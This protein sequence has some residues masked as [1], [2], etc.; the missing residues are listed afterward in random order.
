MIH[1]KIAFAFL[2]AVLLLAAPVRAE[3][4]PGGTLDQSTWEQAKGMLPEEILNHYRDGKLV[5]PVGTAVAPF[6]L[7]KSFLAASQ[8]N[9]GKFK[10]GELGTL[11]EAATGKAPEY[12]FGAPFPKLDPAD[13]ELASKVIW[14]FE[15]GYWSNGSN[16]LVSKLSWMSA[17]SKQPERAV[18]SQGLAMIIEGN[19]HRVENP[20]QYS[21]LD[22]NFLL[23]PADLYGTASLGWRYKDPTKRDSQ[24]AYVPA[25]RRVRAVSPANRSDGVFGSEMTQDDGFNG[26]DGKPEDFTYKV[27]ATA[28]Q[29]M[30]FVPD[31]LEGKIQLVPDKDGQGWGVATPLPDY[32]YRNPDFKG[33]PWAMLKSVLVKRPIWVIEATPKDQYYLFGKLVMF[34]DRETYKMSNVVKYDWKGQP[35][36]VFCRTISYGQAPDG[37]RYVHLA[38][39]G[40]GGAYSENLR[41]NRATAADVP[42]QPADNEIDAKLEVT[43]FQPD[44]LVQM[45]R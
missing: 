44:R 39:G 41:F 11:I 12:N 40:Q 2:L 26:F 35:V 7:D 45:G 37:Y 9:A 3:I 31:A 34:M 24:W 33:L 6:E 29:Y 13:P 21:R 42:Q 22:R 8:A 38:G 27:V 18:V 28:D 5:S 1:G 16:K 20:N 10:I 30:Y 19:R 25:L 36:S 15:Y 43:E 4:P 14:N 17:T 23:E 32:G